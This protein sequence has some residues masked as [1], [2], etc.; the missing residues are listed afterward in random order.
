MKKSQNRWAE[1]KAAKAFQAH[2][3]PLT[4]YAVKLLKVEHAR[5]VRLVKRE[6]RLMASDE[7]R[8]R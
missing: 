4:G 5:S 6:L 8:R 7:R 2:K 1:K 3:G